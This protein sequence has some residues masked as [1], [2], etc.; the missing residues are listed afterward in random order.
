MWNMIHG[1]PL[2]FQQLIQSDTSVVSQFSIVHTTDTIQRVFCNIMFNKYMNCEYR[3]FET[4]IIY[5]IHSWHV[6]KWFSLNLW[7]INSSLIMVYNIYHL[8]P[9]TTTYLNPKWL[10]PKVE[11]WIKECLYEAIHNYINQLNLINTLLTY[12]W[13]NYVSHTE[14]LSSGEFNNMECSRPSVSII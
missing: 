11:V 10:R 13:I 14:L 8:M 6:T 2:R 12:A 7:S 4:K 9:T 3:C 1:S 5:I